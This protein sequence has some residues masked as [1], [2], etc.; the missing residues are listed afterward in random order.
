M[1]IYKSDD[2][3]NRSLVY[4]L[5]FDEDRQPKSVS[6]EQMITDSYNAYNE[7]IELAENT[8]KR[9]SIVNEVLDRSEPLA[10]WKTLHSRADWYRFLSIIEASGVPGTKVTKIKRLVEE[11]FLVLLDD[12][13][14]DLLNEVQEITGVKDVKVRRGSN[15]LTVTIWYLPNREVIT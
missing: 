1:P 3:N 8:N 11:A 12:A 6:L 2:E 4:S 10:I 5:F 9:I 7:I 15:G 13:K 14:A